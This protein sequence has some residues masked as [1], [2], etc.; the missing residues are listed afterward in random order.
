[1]GR[2]INLVEMFGP[3]SLEIKRNRVKVAGHAAGA[4]LFAWNW[5]KPM[6]PPRENGVIFGA[7]PGQ[8]G[9]GA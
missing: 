5:G 8:R 2:R 7:S 6:P 1:M 3:F 9:P 4:Q